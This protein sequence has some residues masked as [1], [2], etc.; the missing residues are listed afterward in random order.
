MSKLKLFFIIIAVVLIGAGGILFAISLKNGNLINK[1]ETKTYD[2]LLEFE[3]IDLD[4]STSDV[5]IYKSEDGKAK[6]ECDDYEKRYHTVEVIDGTLTIKMVDEYKWYESIMVFRTGS[7]VKIYL[8]KDEYNKLKVNNSTGDI[9][10]PNGFGFNEVSIDLSTGNVEF[11]SVCHGSITIETSTGD[12]TLTNVKANG[13]DLSVDTGK[14]KLN[15]VHVSGNI[16][17]VTSTGKTTLEYVTCVDL[18]SKGSTGD[19]ILTKT[20]ASGKIKIE[21]STGDVKFDMSDGKTL[22]IK[23][24]TGNVKGTLITEKTFYAHSSTKSVNV[25]HTTG[26]MCEIETSTGKIDIEISSNN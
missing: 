2:D 24:S 15:D 9:T 7:K 22:V 23:T 20:I 16:N 5:T 17:L 1:A 18:T 13:L 12:I 25:P 3:N 26:E 6:V 19:I 10:V 8:P 21:R 11:R 4:L 14:I